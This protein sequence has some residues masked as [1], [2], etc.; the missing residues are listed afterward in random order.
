MNVPTL[1]RAWREAKYRNAETRR[2]A[3][4]PRWCAWYVKRVRFL[5][6]DDL[7]SRTATALTARLRLSREVV[8]FASVIR[9]VFP[10]VRSG[11]TKSAAESRSPGDK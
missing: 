6:R 11:A 2:M 3:E 10:V 7:S 8:D 5:R 4:I 1:S 9:S